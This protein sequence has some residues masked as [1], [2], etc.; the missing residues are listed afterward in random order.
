MDDTNLKKSRSAF[1]SILGAL[2]PRRLEKANREFNARPRV[3]LAGKVIIVGAI[4]TL[5]FALIYPPASFVIVIVTWI[6]AVV[7]MVSSSFN[8]P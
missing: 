7:L 6:I 5:V 3:K 1:L 8:N 2:D 4:L